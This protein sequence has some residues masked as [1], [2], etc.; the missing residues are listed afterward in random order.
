LQVEDHAASFYGY[1]TL[2]TLRNGEVVGML[3][4]NGYTGAA[5]LHS[6]HGAYLGMAHDDE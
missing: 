2:H 3:S 1:D 5:W 4:V 6:G